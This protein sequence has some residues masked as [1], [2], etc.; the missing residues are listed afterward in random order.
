MEKPGS[1]PA[2]GY[3]GPPVYGAAGHPGPPVYH[4]GP[5]GA[6]PPPQAAYGY[7]GPSYGAGY[8]GGGPSYGA[9]PPPAARPVVIV[10]PGPGGGYPGANAYSGSGLKYVADA[11]AAVRRG[12]I[13]KVYGILCTQLSITLAFV[14]AFS[15]D[16]GLRDAVVGVPGLLI[17]AI[18]LSLVFLFALSCFP[19]VARSYPGNYL[20]LFGF[21]LVR[22]HPASALPSPRGQP[23]HP[24]P[25]P[26][27]PSLPRAV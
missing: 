24:L 4:Q 8:G 15:F 19:S 6:P 17:A 11:D 18:I 10:A 13:V 26:L 23:A 21:T 27:P 14:L 9:P 22:A 25:P 16:K 7:G 2:A 5:Y 3:P 1:Y 12:F 20:C